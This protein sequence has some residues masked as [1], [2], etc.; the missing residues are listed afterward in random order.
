MAD[1]PPMVTTQE[2]ADIL[3]VSQ[4]TVLRMDAAGRLPAAIK[5]P[6]ATLFLRSEVEQMAE[7]RRIV[8][9]TKDTT[10]PAPAGA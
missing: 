9:G 3:G 8:K 6:N 4:D 5:L 7:A 10:E 2:A 1:I